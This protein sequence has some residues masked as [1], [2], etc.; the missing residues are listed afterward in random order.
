MRSAIHGEKNNGKSNIAWRTS[1][2]RIHGWYFRH[3]LNLIHS[4]LSTVHR[5]PYSPILLS[6]AIAKSRPYSLIT[7]N[8]NTFKIHKLKQ[9]PCSLEVMAIHKYS[10]KFKDK[11]NLY[12][13]THNISNAH[14]WTTNFLRCHYTVRISSDI[15]DHP[16][17]CSVSRKCCLPLSQPTHKTDKAKLPMAD[18]N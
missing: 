3:N 8:A 5:K 14:T 12:G 11:C 6:I 10:G 17:L 13:N 2:N 9:T 1:Y 7:W 4:R 15:L 16:R 18:V